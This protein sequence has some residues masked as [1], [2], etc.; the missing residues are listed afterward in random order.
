MNINDIMKRTV[1]KTIKTKLWKSFGKEKLGS[2]TK[3][4]QKSLKI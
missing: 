2:L 3:V 1:I 4:N